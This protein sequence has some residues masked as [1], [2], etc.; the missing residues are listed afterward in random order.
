MVSTGP[1]P[2]TSLFVPMDWWWKI[3]WCK[4]WPGLN[5]ISCKLGMSAAHW[6]LLIQASVFLSARS[7][8]SSAPTCFTFTLSAAV[9]PTAHCGSPQP[10]WMTARWRPCSSAS[11]PSESCKFGWGTQDRWSSSRP[12][13]HHIYLKRKMGIQSDE[14]LKEQKWPFIGAAACHVNV[15]YIYENVC[16]NT[17]Q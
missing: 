6:S 15:L 7:R 8:S 14:K 13:M 5:F 16:S 12:A 3:T 9:S 17:S 2:L 11:S 4:E 1:F 10:L